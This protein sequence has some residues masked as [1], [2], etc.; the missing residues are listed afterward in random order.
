LHGA[1][2]R[3]QECPRHGK[4]ATLDRARILRV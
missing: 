1:Y 2:A 4:S 3:R